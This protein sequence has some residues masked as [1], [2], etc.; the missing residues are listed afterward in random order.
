[1]EDLIPLII[2]ILWLLY[3]FYSRGQKKKARREQDPGNRSTQ[4]PSFLE[5]LLAGEGIQ[6]ETEPL[7]EPE[8]DIPYEPLEEQM[9]VAE[10]REKKYGS[11]FLDDELSTFKEEGQLQFMEAPMDDES[12]DGTRQFSPAELHAYAQDFDLRKAVVF[13]VILEAPYIDYK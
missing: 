13:S 2:G 6:F 3:T 12:D 5:Q 7:E 10:Y 9:T 1:M 11:P 8:E 4:K